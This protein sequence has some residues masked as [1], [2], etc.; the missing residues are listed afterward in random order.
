VTNEGEFDVYIIQDSVSEVTIEA[1]SNLIPAIR[2]EMHGSAMEIDTRDHLKPH[3]PMK[4]YIHTPEV[5]E[6]TLSGSG[7]IHGEN[8]FTNTLDLNLSGSG[9]ILFGAEAD[10][11]DCDI[12]GSGTTELGLTA[13]QIKASISGSGEMEFYGDADSG[14]FEITGSGAIHAYDLL[15]QECYATINGSGNIYVNVE[16]YLDVT[17]TGSGNVYYSGNPIIDSH[18][19]GSGSVIHP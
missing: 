15:L 13:D 5:N 3:Y 2:T 6:V 11:I 12:S 16:D 1:E 19:T 9:D 18:I 4:L 14:E 10:I 8:I 17:I 7:L